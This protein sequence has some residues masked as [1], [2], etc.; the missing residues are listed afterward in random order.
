M[1]YIPLDNASTVVYSF[2]NFAIQ[3]QNSRVLRRSFI[4]TSQDLRYQWR[5]GQGSIVYVHAPGG[6]YESIKRAST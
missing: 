3:L 6:I 5:P 4:A 1:Q 2:N